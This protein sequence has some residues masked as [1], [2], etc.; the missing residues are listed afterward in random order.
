MEYRRMGKSGLKLSELSLGSW[1]TFGAKN[2]LDSVKEQ[3]RIAIDHGVN[4]FDNAEVYANGASELL[5]GEALRTY[6]REDL[7]LSTKIFW[8]GP[9]PND[10]GHNHK[11]LMEGLKNALRRLQVDYVDLVYCHRKDHDTSVEEAV[12]TMDIIIK[13]GLAFYWG[14]SEWDPKE[15]EEAYQVAKALNL[16]PPSVEQP[17][18]NLFKRNRVEKEYAPLYQKYGLGTTVWSPLASG[19]LTGKYANGVPK[20]SRLD[21][22][23]EFKPGD[24]EERVEKAKKLQKVAD[25]LGVKLSQLA[26]AWT[27]KNPH[28]STCLIAGTTGDQLKENLASIHVKDKLSKDILDEMNKIVG[29]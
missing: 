15:I 13:K 11:H 22:F 17:E 18:Y 2:H 4:F 23:P 8:G 29:E 16:T 27:L 14:T 21:T 26:I 3:I 24:F 12:R 5:M 1:L 25:K 28:V 7:V 20:G 9:G 10:T 19:L 6:R